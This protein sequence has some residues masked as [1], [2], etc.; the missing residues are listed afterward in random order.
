M[1]VWYLHVLWQREKGRDVNIYS[2]LEVQKPLQA[3]HKHYNLVLFPFMYYCWTSGEKNEPTMQLNIMCFASRQRVFRGRKC[4]DVQIL[5]CLF[6][7][8]FVLFTNVEKCSSHVVFGFGKG[9]DGW[10]RQDDVNG[11]HVCL[12]VCL[13]HPFYP[14]ALLL[15]FGSCPGGF[16]NKK[17]H[18]QLNCEQQNWVKDDWGTGFW[19]VSIRHHSVCIGR[20]FRPSMWSPAACP[21]DRHP[22]RWSISQDSKTRWHNTVTTE[23]RSFSEWQQRSDWRSEERWCFVNWIMGWGREDFY[24]SL[25][26][27]NLSMGSCEGE[28]GNS[29]EQD[30]FGFPINSNKYSSVVITW[31]SF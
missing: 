27:G 15:A 12:S 25:R 26:L 22:P 7:F 13:P 17:R 8:Q 29:R 19:H 9:G 16:K 11:E 5:S 31:C 24:T 28:K 10:I 18:S 23:T 21:A 30:V 2:M 4:N 14:A 3:S 1:P 6:Y 20:H